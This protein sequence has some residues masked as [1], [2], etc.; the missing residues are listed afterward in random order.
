[1]TVQ[2]PFD[3]TGPLQMP[4]MLRTLQSQGTVHRIRTRVGDDAWLVTGYDEVRRLLADDRLGRAWAAPSDIVLI[5]L[6]SSSP[7]L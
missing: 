5:R 4:T 7:N 1:M 6:P 3:Q 2:L